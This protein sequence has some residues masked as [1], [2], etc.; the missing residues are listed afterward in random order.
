L[1][2]ELNFWFVVDLG[3]LAV[4]LPKLNIVAVNRAAAPASKQLAGRT[5]SIQKS[6]VKHSV[7]LFSRRMSHLPSWKAGSQKISRW[8]R[9]RSC[10]LYLG[11]SIVF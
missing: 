1:I 2:N 9:S 11:Q 5:A 7:W 4:A 8:H 10:C 6:F 3:Y